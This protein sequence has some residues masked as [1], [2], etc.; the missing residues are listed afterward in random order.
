MR[1]NNPE[2]FFVLIDCIKMILMVH[3]ENQNDIYG[4]MVHHENHNYI[5][6]LMMLHENQ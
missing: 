5:S 4:L 1:I 2:I 6:G 3:H